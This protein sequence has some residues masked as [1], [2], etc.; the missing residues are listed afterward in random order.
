MARKR[1]RKNSDTEYADAVV[2]YPK[3]RR[4]SMAS[5]DVGIS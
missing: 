2:F 5:K 4:F 1:M 3:R